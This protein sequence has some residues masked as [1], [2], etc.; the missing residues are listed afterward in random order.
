MRFLKATLA[1]LIYISS[2]L[3]YSCVIPD[4][5][6]Y[7]KFSPDTSELGKEEA[8]KIAKWLIDWRE[9]E[10]IK[11]AIV[12]SNITKEDRDFNQVSNQRVKNIASLLTPLLEEKT[13]IKYGTSIRNYSVEKSKYDD[14]NEIQISIQPEC[15]RTGNCCGGNSR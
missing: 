3:A 12:F 7:I 13:E 4:L 5:Q 1:S 15:K 2:P 9:K 8:T 14:L 10:G 6:Y 11:Y